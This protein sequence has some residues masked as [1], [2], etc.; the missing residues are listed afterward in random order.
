MN[1][2]AEMSIEALGKLV[3]IVLIA[4]GVIVFIIVGMNAQVSSYNQTSGSIIGNLSGQA[5]EQGS[6][7]IK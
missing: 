6:L 4:V 2:K 5:H 1:N 3:L 7:I